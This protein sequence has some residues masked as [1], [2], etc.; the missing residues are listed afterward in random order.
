MTNFRTDLSRV[1]GLG[2]IKAGTEHFLMQRVSGAGVLLLLLF[3][4]YSGFRLAGQPLPVVR[5]YFASPVVAA[6]AA[7]FVLVSAYHMRIGMQVIIED[8]VHGKSAT[9]ISLLLNSFFA[10]LVATAGVFAIIKL[11]LGA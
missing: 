2:S 5:A 6:L 9:I 7:L 3:L 11:S 4:F 10:A 8:Y 1:R